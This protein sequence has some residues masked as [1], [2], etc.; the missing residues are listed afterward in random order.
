MKIVQLNE[1]VTFTAII[2]D[3]WNDTFYSYDGWAVD[4]ADAI[5]KI[6]TYVDELNKDTPFTVYYIE[7]YDIFE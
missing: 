3:A 4:E 7:D 2:G 6:E 1:A 5:E